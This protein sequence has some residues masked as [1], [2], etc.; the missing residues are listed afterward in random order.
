MLK[1][2]LK[3]KINDFLREVYLEIAY[4]VY[5]LRNKKDVAH[6]VP[7]I[8]PSI[9]DAQLVYA[10]CSTLF[11]EIL[12]ECVKSHGEVIDINV[13]SRILSNVI[14]KEL[15]FVEQITEGKIIVYK[16]KSALEKILFLLY[17]P[18]EW[19]HKDVIFKSLLHEKSKDAIRMA[20][21]NGLKKCLIAKSDD[22]MKY[23]ITLKGIKYIEDRIF[24][25]LNIGI[26]HV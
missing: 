14:R 10:A 13:V 26:T 7:G 17:Y 3:G 21:R 8:D 6:V 15:P 25:E 18:N 11:N 22:G 19:T 5:Q 20:L 23:K 1:S 16:G 4:N 24:K 12:S 2:S 9:F